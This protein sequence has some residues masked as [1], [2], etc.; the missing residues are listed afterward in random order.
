[1]TRA[2]KKRGEREKERDGGFANIMMEC[3]VSV[4]VS[5]AVSVSVSVSV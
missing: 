4:S 3:Y 2:G 1:M 5:V